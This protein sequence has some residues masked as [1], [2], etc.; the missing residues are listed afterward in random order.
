[1]KQYRS[2]A[3]SVVL[4]GTCRCQSGFAVFAGLHFVREWR[5]RLLRGRGELAPRTGPSYYLS[6]IRLLRVRAAIGEILLIVVAST[7]SSIPC[8]VTPLCRPRNP[9]PVA[10]SASLMRSCPC[11]NGLPSSA[12]SYVEEI[13]ARRATR[14]E[15]VGGGGGGGQ[16]GGYLACVGEAGRRGGGGGGGG[17]GRVGGGGAD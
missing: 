11:F 4:P 10:E 13:F 1:M 7:R 14:Q 2:R 15:G 12:A 5:V 9:E 6:A 16:G 17:G 3:G 8:V